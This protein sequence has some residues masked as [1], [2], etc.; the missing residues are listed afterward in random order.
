MASTQRA[1]GKVENRSRQTGR[2]LRRRCFGTPHLP[3]RSLRC[4]YGFPTLPSQAD[5]MPLMQ[6]A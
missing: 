5:E 1:A 6:P 4:P 3:P 2:S